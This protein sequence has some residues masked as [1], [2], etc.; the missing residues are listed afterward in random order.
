MEIL[1]KSKNFRHTLL[2]KIEII[3]DLEIASNSMYFQFN[4]MYQVDQAQSMCFVH[5]KPKDNSNFQDENSPN[6]VTTYK[7]N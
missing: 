6:M 2:P 1:M 4:F 7:S 5:H 3:R